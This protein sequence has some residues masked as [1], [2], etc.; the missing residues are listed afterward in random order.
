VA[1]RIVQVGEPA[2]WFVCRSP[3]NPQYHFESIA[4]RYVVLCFFGSAADPISR[5]VLDR[6]LSCQHVFDDANACF[7]GVSIDPEDETKSRV[8]NV[9]PGFRFLWDFDQSVSR[10]F[11]V[12]LDTD[13]ETNSATYRRV[14]FVLDERLRVLKILAFGEN[15][16]HQVAQLVDFLKGMPAIATSELAG[17]PAPVLI[18]PRIFEP[19]FCQVLID[20][21]DSHGGQESGFMRD[22]DGKTVEIV[23]HNFKQRR[24]QVIRDQRL[25]TAT[26]HRIHDRL[27]PEVHKAFQ[28]RATRIERYIVSCY[29]STTGGHFRPHRDNLTKGTAHRQFAVSLNLNSEYE[30][31]NLRFPEFGQQTYKAP[32]GGAVV[33]SCSLLHEATPITMGKRYAF[34][35]FLYDE[36]AAKIRQQNLKYL[37]DTR[38]PG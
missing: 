6:V 19:G 14:T 1:Q 8:E 38:H 10:L 11:G 23:D 21:Y 5:R 20:Y 29:E 3:T 22:V 35:P 12:I 13:D 33:F 24:D 34:L 9:I 36:E 30:G 2:P 28:F 7:F 31:G 32:V 25:R 26:M 37:G 17:Q 16:D 4:G 27:V 18:V 15:P